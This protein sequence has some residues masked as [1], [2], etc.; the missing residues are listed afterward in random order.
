[1]TSMRLLKS[2]AVAT[3]I[4]T[5]AAVAQAGTTQARAA[6]DT[7]RNDAQVARVDRHDDDRHDAGGRCGVRKQR[8]HDG[9]AHWMT[10]VLL[11]VANS[12]EPGQGAYGW[13]YFSAARKARAVVISPA[14]EYFLSRGDG[15]RQITGPAGQLLATMAAE[16]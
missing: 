15:P 7:C 3:T 6:Q 1:M 10:P 2:I 16:N 14:G 8:S 12:S 9:R 4:V 5:G 13:Q 11:P